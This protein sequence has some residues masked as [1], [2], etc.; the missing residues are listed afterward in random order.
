MAGSVSFDTEPG[1]DNNAPRIVSDAD[2]RTFS[3]AVFIHFGVA[4]SLSPPAAGLT[5]G[6]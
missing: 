4:R 3:A 6:W 5:S 2:L 1:G